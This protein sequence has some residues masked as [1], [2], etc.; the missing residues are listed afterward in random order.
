MYTHRIRYLYFYKWE[1]SCTSTYEILTL[2]QSEEN[3]GLQSVLN[4]S[5]QTI[6]VQW[7][8]ERK[9]TERSTQ[10][11]IVK[12]NVILLTASKNESSKNR[13][14]IK[15]ETSC[16]RPLTE[17]ERSLLNFMHLKKWGEKK[18]NQ[19]K[20]QQPMVSLKKKKR[21]H[22]EKRS[23]LQVLHQGSFTACVWCVINNVHTVSNSTTLCGLS[24]TYPCVSMYFWCVI[25]NVHTVSNHS[26]LQS[27]MAVPLCQSLTMSCERSIG[28]RNCDCA[29]Q[30]SKK[31]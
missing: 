4:Y 23:S 20:K 31:H 12:R 6:R 14:V 21:R 25:S 2:E 18:K 30:L 19:T 11:Q 3:V 13:G 8:Q 27:M 22:K 1:I 9:S 17:N 29:A 26:M 7:S 15:S 10:F 24:K 28:S 5:W 16:Q